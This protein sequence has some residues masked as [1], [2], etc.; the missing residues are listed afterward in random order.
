MLEV[1]DLDEAVGFINAR[2]KPLALYLFTG[3]PEAGE[4][5]LAR[6]SAGGSCINDTML[7]FAHPHLP[8]GGVNRSGLGKAHGYFGFQAFSN[9]RGMLRSSRFSPI[10]WM[11][12]PFTPTVRRLIDLTLR[13]L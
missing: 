5:I 7:Q 11:Y 1:A 9:A 8:G 12:P 10:Q 2:P 4:A 3:R 6:T 13:H